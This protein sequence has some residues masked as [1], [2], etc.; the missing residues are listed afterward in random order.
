MKKENYKKRAR[1]LCILWFAAL[2]ITG[3]CASI[4]LNTYDETGG[5]APLELFSSYQFFVLAYIL[6]FSGPLL[7]LI[8][9]YAKIANMKKTR[10]FSSIMLLQHSGWLLLLIIEMIALL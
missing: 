5:I 8:R 1:N 4:Y 10:I 6:F 3:S 7:V 2:L 9:Y